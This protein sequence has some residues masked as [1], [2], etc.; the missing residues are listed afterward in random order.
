MSDLGIYQD[1]S[2]INEVSSCEIT[3]KV[4]SRIVCFRMGGPLFFGASEKFVQSV[5]A[6]PNMR[7]LILRMR[8]AP[9]IDTTGVVALR[10]IR[11]Q[12]KRQ[13][14]ELILSGPQENVAKR[15]KDTQF[16]NELGE[17]NVFEW[18]REAML[19]AQRRLSSEHIT[20]VS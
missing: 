10:T 3:P 2:L 7:F 6:H 16:L 1:D 19:T 5:G 12:L 13:G 18:T 11:G 20:Q 9:M 14:C 17:H 4:D 15:L 8:R